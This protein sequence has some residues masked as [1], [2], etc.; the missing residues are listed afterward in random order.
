MK[1]MSMIY[2]KIRHRLNDDWAFGNGM[3]H[4]C[5]FLT[6]IL[7]DLILIPRKL[8]HFKLFIVIMVLRSCIRSINPVLCAPSCL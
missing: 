3:L 4:Y 1:I 5:F 7:L 6:T 8:F 2:H